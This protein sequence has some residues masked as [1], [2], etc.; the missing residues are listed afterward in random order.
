MARPRKT[1]TDKE[2]Q[3]MEQLAKCYCSDEEIAAFLKVSETTVKRHFGPLLKVA[4]TAGRA[5]LR[6]KQYDLAMKGNA[7]MLI[8]LGKQTLGQRDKSE[9]HETFEPLILNMPLKGE[10]V[11]VTKKGSQHVSHSTPATSELPQV[12]VLPAEPSEKRD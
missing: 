6:A 12:P 8:W 5:N 2:I 1:F 3:Q 7:T 4:R 9:V 10:S 11:T